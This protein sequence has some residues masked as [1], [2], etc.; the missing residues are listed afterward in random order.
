MRRFTAAL[1]IVCVLSS[2]GMLMAQQNA[3]Q[4]VVQPAQSVLIVKVY[5]VKDLA[6]WSENGT[7]FDPSILIA[8][9]K[10]KVAPDQWDGKRNIL[11]FAEKAM[12]VVNT[13]QDVHESIANSLAELRKN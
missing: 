11:P 4:E 12:L 13:T 10:S 6:V 2:L 1:M 7:K 5:A 3:K 8:L 9:L